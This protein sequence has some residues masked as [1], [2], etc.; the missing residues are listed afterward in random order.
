MPAGVD[1]AYA[2]QIG[3]A[4]AESRSARGM[5]Q[6][7][8]RVMVGNSKNAVSNWE[9]GV[10]VPTVQNLRELCRVL[11]VPPERL[12]ALNGAQRRERQTQLAADAEA[13]ASRLATLR[14]A[15]EQTAPDLIG[16]LRE[17]EQEARR[18]G[19]EE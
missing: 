11:R 5:T 4:I 17:A 2:R 19:A 16:A 18:M 6:E 10:S 3:R 9:R 15:V 7:E 14:E 1:P 12:L 13:L 8:L